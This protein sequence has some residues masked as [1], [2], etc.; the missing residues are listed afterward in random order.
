M[1]LARLIMMQLSGWAE[2][3]VVIMEAISD[4]MCSFAHKAWLFAVHC[5]SHPPSLETQIHLLSLCCSDTLL[6]PTWVCH[7]NFSTLT[8][9]LILLYTIIQNRVSTS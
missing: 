7:Y 1:G 5:P 2:L 8:P 4:R 3:V 6:Q 9:I